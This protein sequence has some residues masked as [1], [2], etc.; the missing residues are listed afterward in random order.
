MP[1]HHIIM[2]HN[3][4]FYRTLERNAFKLWWKSVLIAQLNRQFKRKCDVMGNF[5]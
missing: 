1:I 5:Y 2:N 3:K 4:N